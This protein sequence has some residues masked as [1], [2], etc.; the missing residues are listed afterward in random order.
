[1]FG[2]WME[3]VDEAPAA[4]G[5]KRSDAFVTDRSWISH[6]AAPLEA[7][8]T[9]RAN[10]HLRL[11]PVLDANQA[12]IGALLERRMR[13]IL[14]SPFGHAL[15]KNPCFGGRLDQHIQPCPTIEAGCSIEEMLAEYARHEAACEGLVVTRAG[16]FVGVIGDTMLI[17]LAATR[18]SEIA[19]ERAARFERLALASAAFRG[20][21]ADLARELAELSEHF[22][23]AASTLAGR[24]SDSGMRSAM[25][26]NATS[27]AADSLREIGQRAHDLAETLAQVERMTGEGRESAARA[28]D[29]T[30]EGGRHM[31]ALS[32]AAN[33]IGTV[34]ALIDSIARKTAMLAINATIEAARAGPSGR[35]FAIVAAEVKSLAAQTR[36]AAATIANRVSNIGSAVGHVSSGYRGIETAVRMAESLSEAI[37]EAMRE[38]RAATEVIAANVDEAGQAAGH[39]QDNAGRISESAGTAAQAAEDLRALALRLAD[40]G[41]TM[42]RRVLGFIETVRAD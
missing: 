35:G 12:P 9:F 30:A 28:V 32:N 18:E 10:P 5:G 3:S 24:A 22:S 1:M 37:F 26:A 17:R 34:T 41:V 11:L 40:H 19:M 2:K 16:R 29:L 13:L 6:D 36:D 38:Q 20:E 8:E 21:A 33:E 7:V 15:L 42:H 27:Q 23:T 25:V 14:F 39:I 31:Q 4:P